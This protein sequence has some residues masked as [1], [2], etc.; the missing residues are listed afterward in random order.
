MMRLVAGKFQRLGFEAAATAARCC[1]VKVDAAA[2]WSTASMASNRMS[3]A[4]AASMMGFP[5]GAASSGASSR[6]VRDC[7]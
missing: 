3:V 5:A 6:T 7:G 4:A 2:G 1:L